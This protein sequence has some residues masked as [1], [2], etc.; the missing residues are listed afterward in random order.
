MTTTPSA[1]KPTDRTVRQTHIVMGIDDTGAVHHYHAP[2]ETVHVVTDSG[3]EHTEAI[4][5]PCDDTRWIAYVQDRRGWDTLW[6]FTSATDARW[7]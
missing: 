4:G 2:T 5:D 7:L 1:E 6:Y 3:R